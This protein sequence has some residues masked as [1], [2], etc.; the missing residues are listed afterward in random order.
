LELFDDIYV[1]NDGQ[2]VE[3]GTLS[4]L[5]QK[6]WLLTTMLDEYQV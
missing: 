3:R 6:Q 1:L 5:Q 2:V 4:E